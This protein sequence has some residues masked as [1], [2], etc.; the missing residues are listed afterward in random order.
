MMSSIFSVTEMCQVCLVSQILKNTYFKEHLSV[1]ASNYSICDMESK[2]QEFTICSM[3]KHS[4]NGK[5]MVYGHIGKGI[6]ASMEYILIIYS[7]NG[8]GMVL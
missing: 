8:K 2:T 1:V 5:D 3:F 6:V 7:T 4:P